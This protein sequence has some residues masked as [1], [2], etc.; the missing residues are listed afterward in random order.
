MVG[1][2]TLLEKVKIELVTVIWTVYTGGCEL[3]G[4]DEGSLCWCLIR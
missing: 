1:C 3:T 4:G 2:K